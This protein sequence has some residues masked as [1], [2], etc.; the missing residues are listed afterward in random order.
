MCLVQPQGLPT[1]QHELQ[2]MCPAGQAFVSKEVDRRDSDMGPA[3]PLP[4][5]A[6]TSNAAPIFPPLEVCLFPET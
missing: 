3:H 1:W 4:P 6:I 5:P 2:A